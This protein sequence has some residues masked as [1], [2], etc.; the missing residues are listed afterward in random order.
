MTARLMALYWALRLAGWVVRLLPLRVSYALARPAGM[1]AFY[2]WRGGRR[3]CIR[4][5]L[6]VAA[7]DAS[8]ARRHARRSFAYYAAYLVDFLRFGALTPEELARIEFDDWSLLEGARTGNGIVFVTL[9]FGNWDLGAARIAERGIPL[10]V[11]ADTFGDRR[12]DELV[13]GARERL[14]MHIIPAT[15]IG[16]GIVRALRR[17]DVV[18]LLIDVPQPESGVEVEFFGSTVAVPDGPARLALRTGAPIVTGLLPRLAPDSDRFRGVMERV[19]F[20]PDGDRE[21]DVREL[22]QVTMR[23]LE[24]MLRRDPEQWYIF[25]T[26]WVE[27]SEAESEE[28]A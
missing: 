22:T 20:V 14:G 16:T 19:A 8:L 12:L 1:A 2:L 27:D 26:L 17:N 23:S 18:A 3:R 7:S 5:M 4:N 6:H 24:R 9:H 15:R 21:R 13:V 11:V 10:S 28:A 25:R